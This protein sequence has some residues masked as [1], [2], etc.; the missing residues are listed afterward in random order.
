MKKILIT[1]SL[2]S[3]FAMISC[4]DYLDIQPKDR[5]IPTTLQEYRELLTS[6]Y[7]AFPNAKSK[8][9]VRTDELEI[10]PKDF[11][12]NNYKDIFLWNDRDYDA[13]TSEFS[14]DLL[15]RSIFYANEV[16]NH[17]G[18]LQSNE[19][20]KQL[21]AEAHALRAYTYFELVNLFAKPY[22]AQQTD[23]KGVPIV[24]TTD[25]EKENRPES[26]AKIYALIEDDLAKAESLMQNEKADEKAPYRFSKISLNALISRVA[27]YKG[28]WQKS[29]DY[30]NKVLAKNNNLLDLNKNDDNILPNQIKSP[31]NI[32][33][34]DY[35]VDSK[36]RQLA[37][38]SDELLKLYDQNDDLRFSLYYTQV[39]DSDKYQTVKGNN[40]DFKCS[41]RIG[42]IMLVKAEALL[43][44]KQ[45]NEAKEV[46]N[47]L[48]K[49]RY[50]AEG[51]KK[52]SENLNSL[53]GENLW[54]EFMNERQREV[55]FEGYRWFDLRRNDQKEITHTY[56][57]VKKV[58][59]KNDPRYTIAFPKSARQ[60]NPFL[61]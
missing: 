38:V 12:A 9:S 13:E 20:Q 39:K 16:I 17:A 42:E 50:N 24:L 19:E 23:E 6:G 49:T 47:Q 48:A 15:Y 14:Y 37:F 46:L 55:A 29:A 21:L 18:E 43:K 31:E 28:E 40:T 1:L 11:S 4:D 41:F 3:S 33:A 34:L 36:V 52:F 35:A 59:Q 10:N 30:A 53:N 61:Q 7:N 22:D 60:E 45:E 51:L 5:V 26:I 25:L 27:L 56:N 44:L 8:A 57:N 32:M 54:I 2:I 58:L